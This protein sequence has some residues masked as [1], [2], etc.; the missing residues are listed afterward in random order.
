MTQK[1]IIFDS[2]TLISFAMNGLYEEI[3]KLKGIFQGKFLITQEVK[4]EV[5]DVPIKINR[6]KF[7]ALKIKSLL[8]DKTLEM[9]SSLKISDGDISKK[10]LEVL[11]IINSAFRGDHKNIHLIDSGEASCLVLSKILADKGI[12]NVIAVDERT[13]RMAVEKPENLRIFLEKKLHTQIK[14]DIEKIKRFGEFKLIRSTELGY[15]LCKKGLLKLKNGVIE[16]LL[17]ALKFKG[18]SISDDEIRE[19]KNLS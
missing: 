15:I 5:I 10:T 2:S 9:P 13:T 8:E 12:D 16:S 11:N 17:Y 14:A 7:E 18:A 1:A 19:M 4:K 6:F 3:R